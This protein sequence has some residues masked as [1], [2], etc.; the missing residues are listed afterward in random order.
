M[1]EWSEVDHPVVSNRDVLIKVTA[2]AVNR[3]DTLQRQ[4]HYPPPA[5]VSDVLGLECAGTVVDV[6]V[7]VDEAWIGRDVCALL[8]GGSYAEYVN[9]PIDCVMPVPI[10]LDMTQAAALPEVA[11]TAWSN[12][13][14]TAGLEAD[15]FVLIHGGAGGVGTHAIQLAKALGARVAVTAGSAQK[16]EACAE[17]GAEV[18][19]NYREEDFVAAI[20][21]ATG[22]QGADVILDIMGAKYWDSNLRAL[23]TDG[24][25][26]IIGLQGGRKTEVNLATLLSKRISV[27]GTTLRAR[28]NREKGD[29]CREVVDV[30][31]PMIEEQ[32][33]R[34]VIDSVLPIEQAGDAHRRLESGDAIGKIVLAVG[35]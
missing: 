34:P 26:V 23:S 30:V 10:G 32:R 2:T 29:I 31:W 11:C 21:Q 15:E 8:S 16:L 33:I 27:F 19:I 17:L 9:A 5:G 13:V 6:G 3:A 1:L 28:P 14:M 20:A 12:L 22:R 4:G 25:L 35:S 18:L 24:R 7:D